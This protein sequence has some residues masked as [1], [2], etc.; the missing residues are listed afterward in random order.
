M[1]SRSL[2]PAGQ[3]RR[4]DQGRIQPLQGRAPSGQTGGTAP[5]TPDRARADPSGPHQPLQP[6]LRV[7][8]LPVAGLSQRQGLPDDRPD[9]VGQ[10]PGNHRFL[11]GTWRAGHPVH[12][13][14]RAPRPS[15]HRRRLPPHPGPRS[16]SGPGLQRTSLKRRTPRPVD[17]RGLGAHQR[18]RRTQGNLFPHPP[19]PGGNP[20]T[21]AGQHR[22]AG[23]NEKENHPGRGLCRQRREL[24][25]NLRRLPAVQ[26]PW[27]RQL[28]HFRR[29][30]PLR[31]G[32]FL[33]LPRHGQGFGP[34]GQGRFRG[35][36]L[37]RVQPLQ[38]PHKR[39]LSRRPGLPLLP[40]EGIRALRRRGPERLHL[41]HARLQRSGPHRL[42]RRPDPGRTVEQPGKTRL[43]RQPRSEKNLPHSLHVP[44]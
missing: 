36:A 3:R 23:Q 40:H 14:R 39:P 17:R 12:R 5:G 1:V 30:Y 31:H 35:P 21:R 11:S 28:P 25:G 4:R 24:P 13:R 20:R 27:R 9:S 44:G 22:Q 7:L 19:G 42:P 15:G 37:H 26:G 16:G 18:G 8:R 43:L 32:L 29:V 33:E 38:R 2:Q 41:L 10:A 34:A 6:E